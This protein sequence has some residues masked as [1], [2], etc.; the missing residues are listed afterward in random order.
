M[1]FFNFGK[2]KNKKRQ[3]QSQ[4]GQ[5]RSG[6]AR[7]RN[8]QNACNGNNPRNHIRSNKYDNSGIRLMKKENGNIIQTMKNHGYSSFEYV[9]HSNPHKG[10]DCLVTVKNGKSTKEYISGPLFTA[11]SRYSRDRD[12][13]AELSETVKK[14]IY[15]SRVPDKD[16]LIEYILQFFNYLC[17]L[18]MEWSPYGT[19]SSIYYYRGKKAYAMDN[20]DNSGTKTLLT[21]DF[22]I[23]NLNMLLSY[24]VISNEPNESRVLCI[25]LCHLTH[26][27]WPTTFLDWL[28]RN[29]Y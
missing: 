27:G 29:G 11:V 14:Y 22:W 21:D 9:D 6:Q 18:N 10:A 28:S 5:R 25:I 17:Q 13:M 8:T 3:E 16:K 26:K 24:N 12:K 23:N 4:Q 19:K 1:H 2:G 20:R 15:D 7:E